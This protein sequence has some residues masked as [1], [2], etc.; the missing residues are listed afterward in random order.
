M[1]LF[2]KH[3]EAEQVQQSGLQ[4]VLSVRDFARR[5]RLE[6]DE[7]ERLVTLFGGFAPRAELLSNARRSAV[8]R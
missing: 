3:V 4:E 5:H 2:M 8:F 1:G 7:E 6:K